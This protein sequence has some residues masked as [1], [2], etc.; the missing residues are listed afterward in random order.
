VLDRR[1]LLEAEKEF[2]RVKGYRE[3]AELVWKLNQL[4][5]SQAQVA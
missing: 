1:R 5:T 2:R 4:A 3:L